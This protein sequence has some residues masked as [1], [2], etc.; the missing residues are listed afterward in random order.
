[1]ITAKGGLVGRIQKVY[2]DYADVLLITDPSSSVDVYIARTGGRGVLVG[3]SRD[4]TYACKIDWLE[5]GSEDKLV[6][7]DD[8]VVT[9][10]LG[11][12]FPSGIPIGHVSA[13][14]TKEY[15]MFQAVEIDPVVDFG[16][17]RTVMV[18]TAPPPPPDPNAGKKKR[19]E[20][21]YGARP[22]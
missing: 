8:L 4:D 6:K 22:Y 10:G 5:R 9:S 17:L 3:L 7:V 16:S 12:A 1:V 20:P 21:A 14:T 11:S 15:S 2:G 13:V 18:L 19:S